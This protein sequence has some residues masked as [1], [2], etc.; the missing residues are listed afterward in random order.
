MNSPSIVNEDTNHLLRLIDRRG[1]RVLW[2]RDLDG[3]WY[4]AVILVDLFDNTELRLNWGGP[5]RSRGGSTTL[6]VAELEDAA[7]RITVLTVRA[8]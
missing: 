2:K 6:L 4:Q 8:G 1:G 5:L 7:L 3:R